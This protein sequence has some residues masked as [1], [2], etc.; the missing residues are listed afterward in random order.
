MT[1]IQS[2]M[3]ILDLW[4]NFKVGQTDLRCTKCDTGEI[5]TQLHLLIY[6]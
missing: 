3:R 4:T 5:E 6:V 2:R 1:T